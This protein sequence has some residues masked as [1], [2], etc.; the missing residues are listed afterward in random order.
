MGIG[1]KGQQEKHRL[2]RSWG[3]IL[4]PKVSINLEDSDKTR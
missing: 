1:P 3:R 4:R 2:A